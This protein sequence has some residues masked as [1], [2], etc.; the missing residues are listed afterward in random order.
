MIKPSTQIMATHHQQ[1]LL[2]NPACH[3]SW[4]SAI[5]KTAI[6]TNLP[7]IY[8]CLIFLHFNGSGG[9]FSA[10]PNKRTRPIECT[11]CSIQHHHSTQSNWLK[12]N[13]LGSK[14]PRKVTKGPQYWMNSRLVRHRRPAVGNW[15]RVFTKQLT[16]RC[17]LD[18]GSSAKW[19][20]GELTTLGSSLIKSSCALAGHSKGPIVN[21]TECRDLDCS[22]LINCNLECKYCTRELIRAAFN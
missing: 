18:A 17:T 7:Q 13:L 16:K 8:D 11:V 14:P 3:T 5:R 4:S 1:L 2:H 19:A 12:A 21:W 20:I 10:I 22:W 15:S 6:A 9:A